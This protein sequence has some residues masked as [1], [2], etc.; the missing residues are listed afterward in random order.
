[1]PEVLC[2]HGPPSEVC[3]KRLGFAHDL[4]RVAVNGGVNPCLHC[5]KDMDLS[6]L[7]REILR[8]NTSA[9]EKAETFMRKSQ[10]NGLSKDEWRQL[11]AGI[12]EDVEKGIGVLMS[13]GTQLHLH[14]RLIVQVNH[15]LVTVHISM[16]ACFH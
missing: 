10:V 5:S 7:R 15:C 4:I 3:A 14:T 12:R 2:L 6:A 11:I 1:M 16:L 13:A 8:S 9:S